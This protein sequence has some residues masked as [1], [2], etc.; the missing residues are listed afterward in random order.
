[1]LLK[2]LGKGVLVNTKARVSAIKN[3]PRDTVGAFCVGLLSMT[4]GFIHFP[5]CHKREGT[6]FMANLFCAI[7]FQHS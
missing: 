5:D 6:G 2:Y 7:L 4:Y 3:V 1:M